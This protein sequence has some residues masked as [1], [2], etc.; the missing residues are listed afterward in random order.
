MLKLKFEKKYIAAGTLL[1]LIGNLTIGGIL[2]PLQNAKA[3]PVV[4]VGDPYTIWQ[5]IQDYAEWAWEMVEDA[6]D[7]M[8]ELSEEVADWISATIDEWTLADT[9]Y[10]RALKYA[11]TVLKKKLLD[12]LVDDIVQWIKGGGTPKIVTDWKGF[13]TNAADQAGGQFVDKY[14]GLGLL[15]GKFAPQLRFV[16]VTPRTFDTAVRCKLSDMGKN[17]GN[18]FN[19]FTNGGWTNWLQVT[20]T[21]GNIYGTYLT[22]LDQK[23]GLEAQAAQSAQNEGVSSSGFLGDKV[24]IKRQCPNRTTNQPGPVENYSGTAPTGGWKQDELDQGEGNFCECLQWE[25]RTPGKI[26]GDMTAKA[27]GKDIDWLIS[28]KEFSEYIGAILDAVI[29]R[30]TKEGLTT[31]KTF[32]GSSGQS[33]AGISTTA[34]AAGAGVNLSAYDDATQNGNSAAALVEQENLLKENQGKYLTEQQ[35]T[36][37]V[38]NQIKDTQDGSLT[39]L[40]DMLSSGCSLPAGVTFTH[41]ETAGNCAI[42]CPCA[43]TATDT[44][45]TVGTKAIIQKITTQQKGELRTTTDLDGNMTSTCVSPSPPAASACHNSCVYSSSAATYQISTSTPASTSAPTV[46]TEIFS[47]TIAIAATQSQLSKI[48][49]AITDMGNYQKAASDYVNAYEALQRGTDDQATASSTEALMWTAKSKAATSTQAVL[50]TA[51]TDLNKLLQ[52]VQQ[53]SLDAVQKTGDLQPKR[54][55]SND[56][57]FTQDGTYAKDLCN[58]QAKQTEYQNAY[59]TCLQQQQGGGGG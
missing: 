20:E 8:I 17:I 26:L 3:I 6:Y 54:G 34:T 28:S 12:M 53:L 39:I 49:T 59:T 33:G 25:T 41:T 23:T 51:E 29:N 52:K 9:W 58:A 40:K 48:D 46:E 50:N 35:T 44:I 5:T 47:I 56:C 57:A 14:L 10:M 31:L 15:C 1:I 21:Q 4:V 22:L 13:L 18:F 11:F 36:L 43:I 32:G 27:V 7:D 38:L 19:D 16:L 55:F 42:A 2:L 45:T 24:C 30:V 37:G